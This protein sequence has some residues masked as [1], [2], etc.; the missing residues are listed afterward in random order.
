MFN[1][2]LRE[3]RI[4]GT[5]VTRKPTVDGFV[6]AVEVFDKDGEAIVTF[7]GKRKTWPA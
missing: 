2:H 5:W 3:D 1:L 6:T 4:A 7:F